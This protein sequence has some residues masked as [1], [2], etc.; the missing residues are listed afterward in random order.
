M[1]REELITK[2]CNDLLCYVGN[3]SA[4]GATVNEILQTLIESDDLEEYVR[5][6]LIFEYPGFKELGEAERQELIAIF[7]SKIK[8]NLQPLIKKSSIYKI[9]KL[10]LARLRN[11][12]WF[13]RRS[14]A[15]LEKQLKDISNQIYLSQGLDELEARRV[16]SMES[17]AAI[18]LKVLVAREKSL[19]LELKELEKELAGATDTIDLSLEEVDA[20]EPPVPL[21]QNLID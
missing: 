9:Q 19:L 21:E 17:A 4:S 20:L 1:D 3:L 2:I 16:R 10:S 15:R 8:N 6:Y 5:D 14:M 11:S 12:L 18:L 13:L 7:I